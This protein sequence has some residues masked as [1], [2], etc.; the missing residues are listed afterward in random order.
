MNLRSMNVI[1]ESPVR[2]SSK[3]QTQL[4]PDDELPL[5]SL[6]SAIVRHIER[7]LAATS[8]QIEGG[9]GA[10]HLLG[11]NPHTLRAK[12]RKLSIDWN[13]FRR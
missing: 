9:R 8:G 12:M 2:H 7:A 1:P 3:N 5:D 6:D 11:I 10:A 4:P 13:R